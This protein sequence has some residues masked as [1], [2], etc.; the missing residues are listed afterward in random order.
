MDVPRPLSPGVLKVF[1]SDLIETAVT[2]A[3]HGRRKTVR[4]MDVVMAL[5]KMRRPL[6]GHTPFGEGQVGHNA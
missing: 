2:Y 3:E 5:K 6:Y 4:G 1:L